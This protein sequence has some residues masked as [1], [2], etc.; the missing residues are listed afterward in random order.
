[1]LVSRLHF[2]NY[3]TLKKFT[4]AIYHTLDSRTAITDQ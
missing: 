4:T 2:L 1:M 3:D